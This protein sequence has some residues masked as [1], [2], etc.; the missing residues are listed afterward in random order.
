[1]ESLGFATQ[2]SA[3]APLYPPIP[4]NKSLIWIKYDKMTGAGT[5]N[6]ADA[7]ILDTPIYTLL[8]RARAPSLLLYWQGG[9]HRFV[10]N[11]WK[12]LRILV[13][14]TRLPIMKKNS[15]YGTYWYLYSYQEKIISVLVFERNTYLYENNL[16]D[17]QYNGDSIHIDE[18]LSINQIQTIRKTLFWWWLW[19]YLWRLKNKSST[20]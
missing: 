5:L 16:N 12:P 8:S 3:I 2:F 4:Q 7:G 14:R 9:W 13:N 19:V 17:N 18:S 15:S 11:R 6:S 10:V 20:K 1:M